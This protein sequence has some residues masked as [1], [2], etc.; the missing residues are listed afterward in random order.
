VFGYRKST[1]RKNLKMVFKAKSEREILLIERKFYR[2][3]CDM[4][5]EMIKSITISKEQLVKRFLIINPE[6]LKR[7]EKMNKSV[8]VMFG[9]YASYEW[10][11]AIEYYTTF[12]G[13]GIYKRIKNVYFDRLARGIRSK[14]NTTLFDTKTAISGIID[15]EAENIKTII[16][17][18]SDQSPKVNKAYHWVEFMGIKVPCYTGAEMMAKKLDL[19]VTYF[20][21][22]KVKRGYYEAEFVPLA[23]NARTFNDFEITDKFTKILEKQI[24]DVPEFYLWTHKRWKHRHKIPEKFL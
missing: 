24:Y 9:H 21:I 12:K 1:V 23:D 6:E 4:F 10:S 17:F 7:L 11:V 13:V 22:N 19:S 3:L 5:M 14:H 8:V 2:H 15:I 20:K 16:A 18:V